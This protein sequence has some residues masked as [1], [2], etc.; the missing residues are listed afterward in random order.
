MPMNTNA[1]NGEVPQPIPPRRLNRPKEFWEV[2]P[3]DAE[4]VSA[5]RDNPED[6]TG[7]QGAVPQQPEVRCP[8]DGNYW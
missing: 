2:E 1:L 7:Q 5:W 4:V 6:P 3:G 8:H